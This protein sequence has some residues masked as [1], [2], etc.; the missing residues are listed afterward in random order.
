MALATAFDS[1]NNVHVQLGPERANLG[2]ANFQVQI[3]RNRLAESE[4]YNRNLLALVD[5]LTNELATRK[6]RD[7]DF[8]L[9]GTFV[10]RPPPD[11]RLSQLVLP[12][13]PC[14]RRRQE[15]DNLGI[16]ANC[17]GEGTTCIRFRCGRQHTTSHGCPGGVLCE[18]RHDTD[19]WLLGDRERPRW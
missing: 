7:D 4:E 5:N 11:A 18:L 6:L 10:E 12:C 2:A 13:L 9:N 15:C 1:P 19:G 14:V 3:L 16:C 8:F 17:R